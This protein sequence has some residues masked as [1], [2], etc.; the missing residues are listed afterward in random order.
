MQQEKLEE[1]ACG[2]RTTTGSALTIAWNAVALA[3]P[4]KPGPPVGVGAQPPEPSLTSLSRWSRSALET[5]ACAYMHMRFVHA[6]YTHA[7]D[8]HSHA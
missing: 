8:A 3:G 6:S 5:N 2:A 1:D 7:S 4:R